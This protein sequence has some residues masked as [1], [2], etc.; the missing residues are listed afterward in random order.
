MATKWQRFEIKID[1]AY[2]D[3]ERSAIADEIVNYIR[4]RTADG[5]GIIKDGPKSLATARVNFTPY[6]K[7]YIE[8][9]DF[10]IAGKSKGDINLTLSGDMLGALDYL[11]D[12]STKGKI[13]IGY[14]NGS[15]ENGIADGNIRGTYGHSQPI[16]KGRDFLGLTKQ[17]LSSI[18]KKFPVDDRQ[19]RD[20]TIATERL[21][22]RA[23]KAIGGADE[24]IDTD[25]GDGDT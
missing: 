24:V 18:L 1:P 5:K 16:K 13:V 20:L 12:K 6:S 17:E 23:K 21:T 4:E 15:K 22:S 19:S 11:S 25:L 7:T 8:S 9:L 2:T 10:K 3:E 14:E